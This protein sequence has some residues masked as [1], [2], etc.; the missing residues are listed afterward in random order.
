MCPGSAHLAVQI[1]DS[2]R[3]VK[4]NTVVWE[5]LGVSILGKVGLGQTL[6]FGKETNRKILGAGINTW[7]A[8]LIGIY[9]KEGDLGKIE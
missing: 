9:I 5:N 1:R 6:K 4:G 2:S 7:E 8:C 3:T